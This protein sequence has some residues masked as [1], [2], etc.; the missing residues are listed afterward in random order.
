[1]SCCRSVGNKIQLPGQT[2]Q[3]YWRYYSLLLKRSKMNQMTAVRISHQ[4]DFFLFS[5]VATETS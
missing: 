1:M 4:V 2:S 5:D 3:K